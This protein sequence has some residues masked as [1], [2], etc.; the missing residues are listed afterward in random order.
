MTKRRFALEAVWI[1]HDM[2]WVG[3]G[4]DDTGRV[5]GGVVN[6]YLRWYG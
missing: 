6:A 1:I 4:K 2:S 5:G 3:G